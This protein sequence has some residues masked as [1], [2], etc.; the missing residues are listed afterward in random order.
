MAGFLDIE[1]SSP[2]M[3]ADASRT[4]VIFWTAT[5]AYASRFL[6]LPY[7]YNYVELC[8]GTT[9]WSPQA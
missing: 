8:D 1:P 5:K 3:C 7:I 4:G 6:G 9:P 2:I